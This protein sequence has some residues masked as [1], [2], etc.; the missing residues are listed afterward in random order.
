ME[1]RRVRR[2]VRSYGLRFQDFRFLTGVGLEVN[3]RISDGGQTGEDILPIAPVE[4]VLWRDLIS[5]VGSWVLAVE[6]ADFNEPV[7][8]RERETAD[9]DGVDHGDDGGGG[10]DA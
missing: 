1:R 9:D 7:R 8:V 3:S 10:A 5:A 2:K 4:E 6:F